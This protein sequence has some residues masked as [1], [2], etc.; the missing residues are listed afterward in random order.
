MESEDSLECSQEPA[1][2]TF[3]VSAMC[4]TC[5]FHLTIDLM[6]LIIFGEGYKLW[7]SSFITFHSWV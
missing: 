7:S 5:P 2:Y 3:L 6:T 1:T 4:A